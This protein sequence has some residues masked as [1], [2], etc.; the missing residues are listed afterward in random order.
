MKTKGVERELEKYKEHGACCW[1]HVISK[2]NKT[3]AIRAMDAT[4]NSCGTRTRS[5]ATLGKSI[6][7]LA[8]SMIYE[9]VNGCAET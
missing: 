4:R 1:P 3:G 9:N 7:L 6:L 5:R 8:H 2:E